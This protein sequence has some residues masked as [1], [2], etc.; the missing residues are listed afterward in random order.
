MPGIESI[1]DD[2]GNTVPFKVKVLTKKEIDDIYDKYR[3]RVLVRDDKNKPI[4]NR[5]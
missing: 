1:K 5:G 4:F 3:K 2:K